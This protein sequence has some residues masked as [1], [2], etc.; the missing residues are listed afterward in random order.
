MAFIEELGLLIRARYPVVYLATAEEERAE[1]VILACAK[2]QGN[3]A[4]YIWDF[5]DGYQGNLN[6]AGYGRRNPLQAL[7]LLEKL[8]TSAAAIFVCET[9]TAFLDDIAISRK[10]R[11]L[12]R[13]LKSQPKNI[14][15]LSSQLT[16]PEELS[17]TITVL[18]FAL[19]TADEIRQEV[20]ST[21]PSSTGQTLAD[22]PLKPW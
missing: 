13:S 1:S 9:F 18:E 14:I 11:N 7:E 12:A 19:P 6:D 3:R 22:A 2:E 5:V 20:R 8:P 15:I 16:I 17:E 10:L 4:V 21:P